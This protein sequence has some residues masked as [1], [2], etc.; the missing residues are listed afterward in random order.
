[1]N[2]DKSP[3]SEGFIV[4]FF[5]MFWK[6]IGHFVVRAINNGFINGCLS[7]TQNQGVVT[8]IP[9][10]NKRKQFLNKWR[11]ITLL[12]TVYKLASGNIANRLKPV[13]STLNSSN[14][15]CFDKGRYI[16]ENTRLVY[17][18]MKNT[19][20]NSLPWLIVLKDFKKAFD[21]SSFNFIEQVI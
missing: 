20:E 18:I 9:K 7:I 10:E 2:N 6:Q 3:G 12:N 21:T 16:G 1:M 8:C 15:T 11:P 5:K 19:E 14:Q 17:D 13:L 4:N